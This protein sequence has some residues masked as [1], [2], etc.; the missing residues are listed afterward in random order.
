MLLDSAQ[1]KVVRGQ[2]RMHEQSGILKVCRSPLRRIDIG[3]NGL[4]NSSPKVRLPRCGEGKIIKG[5]CIPLARDPGNRDG[6]DLANT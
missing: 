1:I 5:V 3:L 4:P 2:V 6:G